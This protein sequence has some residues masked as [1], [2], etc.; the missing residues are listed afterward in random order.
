LLNWLKSLSLLRPAAKVQYAFDTSW[1]AEILPRLLF[2]KMLCL[3]RKRSERSGRRFVL[4]LLEPGSILKSD[5]PTEILG[6]ILSA[7]RLSTR[8]TDITGWYGNGIT[9]GVIFTEIGAGD[10]SIV[11]LFSGRVTSALGSALGVEEMGNVKLSF[12]VFPDDCAGQ[13]PGVETFSALYPDV[14]HELETKKAFL[15]AKRSMDILG[16][17]IALVVLLPLLLLI[18]AAIKLTSRGPILFKQKRL[19][20]FGMSFTFLKFRSMYVGADQTIHETYVKEFIAASKGA[21]E[22]GTSDEIYKIKTD[23]RVTAIGRVLRRASLDE[24]P[25]FFHALMGQMSLVGPRPPLPYEFDSYKTWHKRRLLAVKPGITGLW[26]VKGRSRVKFDE[27]VRMD[28][29]YARAWSLWL[30]LKILL[31]T[32]RAIATGQG[33]Y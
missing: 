15:L 16:S 10:A 7:L 19:G 13:G 20:Q 21:K 24:L 27:M 9:I 23:P 12:L 5:D 29:E 25:Q 22:D 3:E 28:L 18:A 30:D 14:L 4:M 17:L 11:K 33:A 32:P 6:R 2:M 1:E 31:Q 8:E 26:Q